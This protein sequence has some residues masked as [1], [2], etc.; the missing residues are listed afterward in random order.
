MHSPA[1]Q[2]SHQWI[3]WLTPFYQSSETIFFQE[4]EGSDLHD[5]SGPEMTLMVSQTELL[6]VSV[7]LDKKE[8][9]K[10]LLKWEV[11]QN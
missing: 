4:L 5:L 6:S 11:C 7:Y 10:L 2:N 3:L 1:F 9:V 8:N